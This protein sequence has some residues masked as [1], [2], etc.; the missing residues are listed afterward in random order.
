MPYIVHI[1]MA[2]AAEPTL[3]SRPFTPEQVARFRA[4]GIPADN[5]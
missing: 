5:L 3:S 1:F 2:Y 4:G